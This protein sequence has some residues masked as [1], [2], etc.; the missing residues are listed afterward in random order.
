ML[1]IKKSDINSFKNSNTIGTADISTHKFTE[2]KYNMS[3]SIPLINSLNKISSSP[4]GKSKISNLSF[5]SSSI[6]STHPSLENR[7]KKLQL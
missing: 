4:E 6:F 5:F 7:I 2:L 1:K 3:S